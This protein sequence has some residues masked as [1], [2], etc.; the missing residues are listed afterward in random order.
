MVASNASIEE[1]RLND[2]AEEYKQRGYTV[3][4]SPTPKRLPKFLTKFMPDI[5]AQGPN[6]SVVIE[7]K[8]PARI[9]GMDYWKELS[10]V[11]RQHPGWRLELVINESPVQRPLETISKELIAERIHE[12]EKLG[13]QGMLAAAVLVT[14]SAAEAAMRLASRNHEIALPDVRPSTVI[15]RLYSD[16]LLA[17]EEYDFLVDCMRTRNAVAHGYHEGRLKASFLK[18]LQRIALRLLE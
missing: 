12:G 8:S 5:V 1:S 13:Q 14:W 3:T 10:S 11:V 6:E 4:V 7:V 16:G 15:S 18:R 2:I 17:R 9:R